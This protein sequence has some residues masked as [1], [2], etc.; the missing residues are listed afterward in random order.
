MDFK[1]F[2]IDIIWSFIYNLLMSVGYGYID[3]KV[4]DLVDNF[5]MLIILSKGK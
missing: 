2:D 1:G 5:Y 3:V 4:C